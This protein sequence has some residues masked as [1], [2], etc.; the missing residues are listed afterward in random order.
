MPIKGIDIEKCTNCKLCLKECPASNLSMDEGEG[1][2]IFNPS[3]PCIACGHCIAICPQNAIIYK[4][5]KDEALS[6]EGIQDPNKSISYET[7]YNLIR[8]KRSIRQYKENKVPIETLEKVINSMRYAPTGGNFRQ[9]KCLVI[10]DTEKIKTL[11][12][13][14]INALQPTMPV[15]YNEVLK[16]K[17]ELGIEPIF[18]KAPHIIILYS[19]NT[20]DYVNA[21]I[22]I[23]YGMFCAET[24]G[25][26]TCWI[27]FAFEVFTSNK[28]IRQEIAGIP[29]KVLGVMTIGYPSVKY[30]RAPP[31]PP[32]RTKGLI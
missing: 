30:Y 29:G 6:F 7:M 5:L 20:M 31:R 16:N 19:N 27:G 8:A 28:E 14:I 24:L 22:A 32:L 23:T 9:M 1:R 17:R 11:S 15:E 18:Y 10:S 21:A 25:L 12:E 26:G 2:V 13:S 4:G 3:K